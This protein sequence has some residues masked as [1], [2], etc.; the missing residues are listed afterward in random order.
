MKNTG[1]YTLVDGEKWTKGKSKIKKI[2]FMGKKIK[3]GK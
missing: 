1:V 2:R 3:R